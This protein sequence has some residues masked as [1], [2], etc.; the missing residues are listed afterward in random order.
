MTAREQEE[1]TA[2]RATIRERGTARVWLFFAGI[3]AWGALTVATAALASSPVAVL[4]PLLVLSAA[5][6]AVF[7]LH[8][9]VERIGR[10][11]QAFHE[12]DTPG[13]EQAA[14]AFGRPAGA[15]ATDGL[16]TILFLLATLFNLAPVLVMNP[17]GVELIFVGGAHVL[18]VL[19]VLVARAGAARQRAIDLERFQQLKPGR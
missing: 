17:V 11:V 19:R 1:Y 3:V 4:L 12:A 13:W 2:L 8:A 7:A 10:Y 9:G 5:F 14:M 6:E 16:F 15:I 18:F